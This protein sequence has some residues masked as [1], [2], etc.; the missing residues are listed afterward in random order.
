MIIIE[1]SSVNL[2]TKILI[3]MLVSNTNL[4]LICYD[5]VR[6]AQEG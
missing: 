5:Q 3:K 2:E 4:A 6:F 1:V